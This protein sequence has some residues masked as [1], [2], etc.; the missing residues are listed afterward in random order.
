MDTPCDSISYCINTIAPNNFARVGRANQV[1][2]NNYLVHTQVSCNRYLLAIRLAV[3]P[4][5]VA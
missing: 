4:A 3:L 1:H 2:S 5:Q